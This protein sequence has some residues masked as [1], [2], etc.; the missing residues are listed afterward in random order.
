M[1]CLCFPSLVNHF[2]FQVLLKEVVHVVTLL[3][4]IKKVLASGRIIQA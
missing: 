4:G 3:K 1:L 2:G